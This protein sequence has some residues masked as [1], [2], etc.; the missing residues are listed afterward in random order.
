M[1]DGLLTQKEAAHFLKLSVRQ[2]RRLPL[3][4]VKFGRLVRY[5][6][7]DLENYVALHVEG[8][9]KRKRAA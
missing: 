2:I 7:I 3:R 8:P 5:Q 4:R 9:A 6:L 1:S